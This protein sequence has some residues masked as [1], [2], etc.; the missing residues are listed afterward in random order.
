MLFRSAAI[1]G[2]TADRVVF[3]SGRVVLRTRVEIDHDL[4]IEPDWNAR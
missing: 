4:P 1:A 3:K 2:A